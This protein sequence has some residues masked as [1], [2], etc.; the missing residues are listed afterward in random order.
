MKTVRLFVFIS[1]TILLIFPFSQVSS[2]QQS[3]NDL[4]SQINNARVSRGLT[5]V[6]EN[7]ALNNAAQIQS[8]HLASQ[9]G[10]DLDSVLDWHIGPNG[11]D[12]YNR[13]LNAGFEFGPGWTVD[14]IAYGG[15]ESSTSNDALVWWLRSPVHAT[16]L[17][18]NDNVEIGAGI[19]MG[20]GFTYYVVVFGVDLGS[21]ANTTGGVASTIPTSAVTPEVAPV[22]VATANADGSVF[23]TVESGEALWSIA[24]AYDITIDQ[25]LALNN[26]SENAIIFEGQTLQVRAAFTPTPQ[27]TET[28]TPNPPT[29]TPIPAQTAQAIRTPTAITEEEN[30][31]FL[32]LDNQTMGLTLILISGAGLILIVIGNLA[33]EKAAKN[34][35][36][37]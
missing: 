36:K 8:D 28:N 30:G 34:K 9:Y 33:R 26:L 29:R 22:T 21:G 32:D 12:E 2:A 31:R 14:E 19:T 1:L 24:I 18:N 7:N 35:K 11:E 23:H 13:A 37:D 25:I 4:V 27:P 5:A 16:A 10:S 17:L 6:V 3:S 15:N 20:D